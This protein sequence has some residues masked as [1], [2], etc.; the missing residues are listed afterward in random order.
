M[1]YISVINLTVHHA[2]FHSAHIYFFSKEKLYHSLYVVDEPE[3]DELPEL[4]LLLARFVDEVFSAN[5][6]VDIANPVNITMLTLMIDIK[7]TLPCV[8]ARNPFSELQ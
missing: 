5:A 3:L 4:L 1:N 7:I 2:R 6:A 8:E